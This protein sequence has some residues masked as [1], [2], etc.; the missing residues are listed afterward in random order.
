MSHAVRL[1]LLRCTLIA[2]F[3][4]ALVP[5]YAVYDLPQS[6]SEQAEMASIFGD[7]ILI[8]TE[9]GFEWMRLSDV[10]QTPHSPAPEKHLKCAMCYM[11]SKG[12]VHH[13]LSPVLLALG[14]PQGAALRVHFAY[15]SP[16]AD[17]I[18][19]HAAAPRAPPAFMS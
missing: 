16:V 11:A 7:K 2:F 10:P 12:G 13:Q 9:R 3:I 15:Q 5:F 6:H 14:L 18:H 17:T 4:G 1:F 19:H 8:C